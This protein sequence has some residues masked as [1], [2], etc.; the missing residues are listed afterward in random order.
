MITP[1]VTLLK[2]DSVTVRN[3]PTFFGG[4]TLSQNSSGYVYLFIEQNTYYFHKALQGQLPKQKHSPKVV[5]EKSCPEKFCKI[6]REGPLMKSFLS[7]ITVC[8]F[9]QRNL[10]QVFCYDFSKVLQN[11]FEQLFLRTQLIQE[12]LNEK[13]TGH[14]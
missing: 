9:L 12:K 2:Q 1:L 11:T 13:V 8:N 4:G 3:V 5:L 7:L 10:P 6:Y 14:T